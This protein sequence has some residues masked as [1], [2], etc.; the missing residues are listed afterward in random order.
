MVA[1]WHAGCA[2]RDAQ[3]ALYETLPFF[4]LLIPVLVACHILCS[5]PS[6]PRHGDAGLRDDEGGDSI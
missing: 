5:V 1:L 3:A 4:L 2:L 6:D